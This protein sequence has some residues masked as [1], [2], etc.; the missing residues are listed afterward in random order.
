[1]DPWDSI[2]DLKKTGGNTKV[3]DFDVGLDDIDDAG[4]IKK[5][6][7]NTKTE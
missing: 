1:M 2:E 7:K 5:V 6:K 3:G 4:N